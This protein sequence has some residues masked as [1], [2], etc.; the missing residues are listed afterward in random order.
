[1]SAANINTSKEDILTNFQRLVQ[2]QYNLG[3]TDYR[4]RLNKLNILEKTIINKRS[5][6]QKA[7]T[8]DLG[9]HSFETDMVDI[10]PILSEIRLVKKNLK[11]WLSRHK[12]RTPLSLFGS[13]SYIVYEPKGVVL[14]IAPW[15][16]PFNLSLIP[17]VTAI[18]A[19]NT[20]IVKPSEMAMSSALLIQEIVSEAFSEDEVCVVLGGVEES[21]Q[22]LE[23]PFNH[24]FFTGSPTV[25][26]IVMSAA[27]KNLTSVTLELGGKSPT[28]IDETANIKQAASRIA[29]AKFTNTGQIC[30]APDYL[31][32]HN[33]VKDEFQNEMIAITKKYYGDNAQKATSYAR[34]VTKKHTERIHHLIKNAVDGGAKIIYG[35]QSDLENKYIEPTI[36]INPNK[37]SA[38]MKEEIFGPL[39]PIVGYDTIDEVINHIQSHPKPLGLYIFSTNQLNIDFIMKNTR[40]GGGCINHC[41]IHFYNHNMPFGG[42]NNSGMGKSHGFE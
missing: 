10:Y 26:K 7:L 3:N 42:S 21:T 30:I 24:I 4:V 13:S 22:L 23:L 8:E 16:F 11:K 36:V 15:N 14:I 32:I 33:S 39:L 37:E 1:M 35:G 20:V 18:A 28:I 12:V 5:L 31:F 6:I 27:A 41:A 38:I 25:G 34:I 17:L 2:N 9:R 29:Q 19:G 40:A